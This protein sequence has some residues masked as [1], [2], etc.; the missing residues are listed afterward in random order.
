MTAPAGEGTLV[1]DPR[2]RAR[3]RE[4]QR[5]HGR[6]RLRRLQAGLGLAA[7][8]AGCWGLAVSPVADVD[9]VVV[10]GANR[11]GVD[12]V[13]EA[14][15]IHRGE[16]MATLNIG[17]ADAAVEHLPWVATA[18]V[19][20]SWPNSVVVVVTERRPVALVVAADGSRVAV[21]AE[22]RQLAVVEKGVFPELVE[23]TGLAPRSDPGA[24][25][26]REA[27]APLEL[28]DL[29]ADAVPG[30]TDELAV[31]EGELEVRLLGSAGEEV[32][33]RFGDGGLLSD[34]VTA[35]AALLQAGVVAEGPPPL[36]ID[37]RVPGAPVLTR[38]G[39]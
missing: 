6:R 24:A 30:L 9:R 11:S 36:E 17:Q 7:L 22:G 14:T 13:E 26:G 12:A 15:G 18:T 37:V 39:G 34:K 29:L 8:G 25:L 3:R 16:A 4:I 2:L 1:L 5:H 33:A 23:I 21:D 28:A 19:A 38:T 35:L 31:V 20:R 27:A 32:L 10:E